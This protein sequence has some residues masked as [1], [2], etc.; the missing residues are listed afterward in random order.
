[1]VETPATG[2]RRRRWLVALIVLAALGLAAAIA[3]HRYSRPQ[4]LADLLVDQV[5]AQLGAELQ[6]GGDAG[7]QLMPRLRA[8][9]PRPRLVAGGRVV[10]QA[11]AIAASVPWRTLWA[12]RLEIEQIELQRPRLD[13]DALRAWLASR[14]AS[15]APA[16][17]VRLALRIVD[18]EVID[19]GTSVAQGI[20]ADFSNHADLVAWL[21]A[22]R[23][24][25]EAR[26]L[27]PPASGRASAESLQFGETR[28]EG[29]RIELRDDTTD[30]RP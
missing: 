2:R 13:L 6:L 11:D 27:L 24:D 23:S 7:F 18:G 29:V 1:M 5:R 14:P 16:P 28:L 20:Q 17:D 8:A 26:T 3:V 21:A 25:G 19:G 15:N 22:L 4:R 12:D 30:P 10:V 9:L